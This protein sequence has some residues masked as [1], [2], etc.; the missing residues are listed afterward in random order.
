[1]VNN[2][3]RLEKNYNDQTG[4]NAVEQE[5]E[6]KF[7]N[8]L[9]FDDAVI[10][11]ISGLAAREVKGILD[12]KG[13]FTSRFGSESVTKGVSVD[14][15]EKQA[16]VD[17]KVILEYGQS[18]PAIFDKV[19]RLVID[20]VRHMTGLDVVEVNMHVSDVMSEKEYMQQKTKDSTN[21]DLK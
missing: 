11:K 9:T 20:Q 18:A 17:L 14:V 16:I 3:S 21:T 6:P 4:V 12:M 1:M 19:T 2:N 10:G 13:G 5:N 15:G 8:S 7:V